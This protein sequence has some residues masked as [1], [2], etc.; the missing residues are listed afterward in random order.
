M[1]DCTFSIVLTIRDMTTADLPAL[2]WTGPL[3]VDHMAEQLRRRDDGG[4]DYL[5]ACLP[6]GLAVA[7]GGVDYEKRADSGTLWQFAVRDTFQSCGIGTALIRACEERIRQRGPTHAEIG[8]D[9]T[10]PR[11]QKLYERLGYVPYGREPDAW[12]QEGP[13]GTIEHYET[14]CVLLRKSLLDGDR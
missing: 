10:N 7:K 13:D 8:V 9:V 4:V 11:A 6:S 2:A 3:H 12:D 14:T 5:I 1:G